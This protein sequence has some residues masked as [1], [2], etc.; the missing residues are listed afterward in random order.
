MYG[1][2][3]CATQLT[4][5]RTQ[6]ERR[7]E[8]S[9]LFGKQLDHDVMNGS[10]EIIVPDEWRRVNEPN[11]Y[12]HLQDYNLFRPMYFKLCFECSVDTRI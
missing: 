10:T 12:R 6:L 1:S 2:V 7:T 5:W 8:I 11:S 9:L 4:P 3:A